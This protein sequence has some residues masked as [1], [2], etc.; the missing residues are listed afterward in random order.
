M[1]VWLETALNGFKQRSTHSQF[2]ARKIPDT[3]HSRM[4]YG[5]AVHSSNQREKLVLTSTQ[6]HS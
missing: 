5:A 6:D 4:E 1:L 3:L 2:L